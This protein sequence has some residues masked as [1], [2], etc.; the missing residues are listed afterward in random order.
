MSSTTLAS[1]AAATAAGWTRTLND[2]G[3]VGS[4]RYVVTL[5]K[6][7]VGEPGTSGAFARAY[8]TGSTSAAAD[9]AAL[10]SV[11]TLRTN[12][13]GADTTKPNLDTQGH[14]THKVDTT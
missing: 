3:V 1:I 5:E 9:T 8:G 7:L 6:Q 10:A 2:S 13:Y 11:N 14:N 12:R 4:G